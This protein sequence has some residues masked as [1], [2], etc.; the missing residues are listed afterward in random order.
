MPDLL[1]DKLTQLSVSTSICQWITSFLTDRQQP[2][3]LGKPTSRTLTISTGAP[4]GSEG[5]TSP[6]TQTTALQRTPLTSS[7][8]LQMTLQ[9]S[10]S[11]R[12]ETSLLTDQRWSSWHQTS[13]DYNGQSG[14]L[15]GLLVP[16]CPAS[17]N[18]TTPEWGKGLR[19]S[20]WT[21]HTQLNLSLNCCPLARHKN[22]FYPQAISHLNNR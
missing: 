11:S 6:S 9:S 4:P 15:R 3:K 12:T 20:F 5:A 14:L 16:L 1:S 17:K 21:P 2:V 19:K 10:D 8:N 22:S 7:L 18:F 13:E